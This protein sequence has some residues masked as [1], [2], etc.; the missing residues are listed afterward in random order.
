MLLRGN[1][2]MMLNCDLMGEMRKSMGN[3]GCGG[4]G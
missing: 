3:D 2:V 1:V 4:Y